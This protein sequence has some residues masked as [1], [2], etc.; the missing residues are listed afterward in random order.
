MEAARGTIKAIYFLRHADC[1]TCGGTGAKPGTRPENCRYCG[2]RGRVVQSTG[3]FSLQT[4]CP[5]C[6]GAGPGDP[7]GL[8]R[9]FGHSL[10]TAGD[11]AQP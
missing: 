4:T 7:R 6:H 3:I 11:R 8:P 1:E 9:V 10:G 2:G 5:S